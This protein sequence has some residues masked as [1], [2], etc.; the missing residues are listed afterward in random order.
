MLVLGGPGRDKPVEIFLR[1]P[2]KVPEGF[3]I[4]LS[5]PAAAFKA[6][7]D[8]PP[9][10]ERFISI[11]FGKVEG[12]PAFAFKPSE[13]LELV[14]EAPKGKG[15]GKEGGESRDPFLWLGEKAAE[16]SLVLG[17]K[18][19][20]NLACRGFQLSATAFYRVEAAPGP[21]KLVKKQ[22]PQLLK[23]AEGNLMSANAKEKQTAG[24]PNGERKDQ[25]INIAKAEIQN[26]EKFRSQISA[27]NTLLENMS[28]GVK[29]NFVVVFHADGVDVPL[30]IAGE[31]PAPPAPKK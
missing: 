3:V 19:D 16:D 14:R 17:F 12:P 23:N 21:Q 22:L 11:Q 10:E 7:I 8:S 27:V 28:D 6:N 26:A 2:V 24:M 31:P 15:K 13:R 25:A 5:K 18:L 30:L 20:P 9:L 29:I 1:S 4:D